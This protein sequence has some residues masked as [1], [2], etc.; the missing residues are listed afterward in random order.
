MYRHRRMEFRLVILSDSRLSVRS[1]ALMTQLRYFE[2]SFNEYE[3]IFFKKFF[4]FRI[5]SC[6]NT[7]TNRGTQLWRVWPAML[8]RRCRR[9]VRR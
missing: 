1:V 3:S 7:E 6:R 4:D 5:V 8:L 2:E 9:C